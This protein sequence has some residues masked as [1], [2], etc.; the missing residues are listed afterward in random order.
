MRIRLFAPLVALLLLAG[1][2]ATNVARAA[3]DPAAGTWKL[4][5]A[6]SKYSPGP[7]PKS[8]TVTITI[9]DGAETYSAETVDASG[10]TV[11]G[12]F[13]AKFGG[14][15]APITGVAYADTIAL[16]RVSPTHIDA[17]LKKGG[18]VMVTV[19]V[20]IAADGKSRT[21]TYTGKN[22]KGQKIH[23]VVFF[24]KAM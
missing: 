15:D 2:V 3:D 9:A 18:E 19:K 16:K 7:A 12:G 23:D 22:E 10:K 21:V 24:D 4:N 5:L 11:S 17:T 14:P 8:Q 20:I 13:T 1:V 6:K